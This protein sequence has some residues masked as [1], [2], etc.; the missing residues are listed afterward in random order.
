M[1]TIDELK[2]DGNGLIPVIVQ[3]QVSGEVL[4]LEPHL[5]AFVGRAELESSDKTAIDGGRYPDKRAAFDTAAAAL[6]NVIAACGA[7][8]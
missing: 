2:F 4:T 3:D 7:A 5:S 1:M 8:F 6:K